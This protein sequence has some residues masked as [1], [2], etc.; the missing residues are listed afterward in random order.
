VGF[1]SRWRFVAAVADTS[2]TPDTGPTFSG[3]VLDDAARAIFGLGD[4]VSW[5][6]PVGRISRRQAIQVPAVKRA[7]D[8]ICGT[9]GAL[10]LTY[11]DKSN[12]VQPN[13]LLSQPERNIPRSVT[14]TRTLE[15]LLFEGISVWRI[16]EQDYR[17]YPTK[18]I[19]LEAGTIDIRRDNHVYVSRDGTNQGTT[20][21]YVPDDQIIRFYSPND[22]LLDAGARAIRTCL[23]LDAA[24]ANYADDPM[25]SGY[26]RSTEAADPLVDEQG[27]TES[28]AD[29]AAREGNAIVALLTNWKTARQAGGIGYVPAGTE[30][31]PLQWDPAQLQLA[32]GRQHAVLEIAR[33]CGIDSEDL[34]V[35]Q[36]SK[37][38][39]NGTQKRE[40]LIDYTLN[41]YATAV[42]DRLSM[43]DVTPT[44]YVARFDYG[45]FAK[46]DEKTRMETYTLG[47]ALGAYGVAEVQRREELP[48][49]TAPKPAAP[50]ITTGPPVLRSVPN[51][52]T[53][54]AAQTATG[55][56]FEAAPD[57]LAFDSD[58]A[59]LGF[60]V[61]EEA[62]TIYGLVAPYGVASTLKNGRRFQFSQGS[63]QVP[64]DPSRVKLLLQHD[65]AT[66]VG[67]AVEFSDSPE[68]LWGKF[69]VA[70]GPEGDRALS[71]AADGVWDGLSVGLRPEATF[72][73]SA[74]PARALNAPLA[75]V[76]LVP[77]PAFQDARVSS[78]NASADEGNTAMK[79]TDLLND[80][81]SY[82]A[83][84]QGDFS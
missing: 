80:Y 4:E 17:G 48:P 1:L 15:D 55:E 58:A 7:R 67:K 69:K 42:Q 8:L 16:V 56:T 22:P 68:G 41:G 25:A 3:V 64:T 39:L 45:G 11:R 72:D 84:S 30:F 47:V 6:S 38:Y 65:R 63:I 60:S 43:G 29:Y 82:L 77:D 27:E 35:Q 40:E 74:S 73:F 76:S 51:Q 9:I 5:T 79:C 62:R 53:P 21:D 12:A 36:S 75:E 61:D 81:G 52:E 59:H 78:V 24:A 32:E 23:K 28:D 18:V 33:L 10:P 13:A 26:F 19:R 57:V 49:F 31:V 50:A 34:G 70:R 71:M 20:W 14:M 37:N 54:L 66:A 2:T 83:L 46:A 44:G